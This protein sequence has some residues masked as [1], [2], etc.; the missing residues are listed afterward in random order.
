M[1]VAAPQPGPDDL[2]GAR[3]GGQKGVKATHVGVTEPGALLGQPVG[4]TNGGID[5]D[6][7]RP[8]A[9]AGPR[10]PGPTDGLVEHPVQ[11]GHVSPG[12]AAQKGA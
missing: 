9:G 11:L 7:D 4:L 12:E 6:G 10:R 8:V 3:H 5:I 2:V 1:G